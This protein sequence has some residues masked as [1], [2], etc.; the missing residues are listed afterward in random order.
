[1][2][3]VRNAD[4]ISHIWCG[5][6]VESNETYQI[7][8][9]EQT[10]WANDDEFL[11][12]IADGKAVINDG[13]SDL[14][15]GKAI[16]ILKQI[17]NYN[18]DKDGNPIYKNIIAE[19]AMLFKPRCFDFQVGKY[20]SL[21]NKNSEMVDLADAE[22]H[23]FDSSLTEL[24]KGAEETD[25]EFQT[26]LDSNCKFTHLY[27][28]PSSRYAIKSGEVRYKGTLTGES[29]LWVEVAPHIPKAYGGSVAFMD[30]GIPLDHYDPK[31]AIIIDGASC[32]II[33]FDDTY[34]SHRLG[35]KIEHEVGDTFSILAIFNIYK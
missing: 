4:S 23:F 15:S 1:M 10:I 12:D 2:L 21:C 30:G 11:T 33:E 31:D 7:Q 35:I 17:D 19:N 18:R 14:S 29:D 32:A 3:T 22:L 9:S 5:Q 24:V 26:R 16:N 20:D 8:A 34:Y 28:T 13:Y 6:T 27:F 25:E